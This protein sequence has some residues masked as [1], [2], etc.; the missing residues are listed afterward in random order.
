SS[1]LTGAAVGLILN[2]FIMGV[3]HGLEGHYIAYGLYHGCILALV[4]IYQKK[5]GFYKRNRQKKWYVAGSWFINLNVVMFGFL[6]FSGYLSN[7]L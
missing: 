6:I 5:S 2:M 3:W 7:V 4:E 1:R